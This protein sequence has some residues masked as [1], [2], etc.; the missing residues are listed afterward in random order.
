MV[1]TKVT[2][3]V[4]L[5]NNGS[6]QKQD[7]NH[8]PLSSPYDRNYNLHSLVGDI[9]RVSF[10]RSQAAAPFPVDINDYFLFRCYLLLAEIEEIST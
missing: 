4:M 5:K 7:K 8:S 3:D 1:N 10:S 6:I 9:G 2:K